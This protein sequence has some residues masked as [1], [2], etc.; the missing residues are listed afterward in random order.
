MRK[1]RSH[2]HQAAQT[3]HCVVAPLDRRLRSVRNRTKDVV[4]RNR[5]HTSAGHAFAAA[6]IAQHCASQSAA[7]SPRHAG[8]Q[9]SS[10]AERQTLNALLRWCASPDILVF[11]CV[12][13]IDRFAID[14]AGSKV[15]CANFSTF[16]AG[17]VHRT[18]APLMAQPHIASNVPVCLA[19]IVRLPQHICVELCAPLAVTLM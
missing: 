4:N 1:L 13:Q 2:S 6:S 15:A 17:C 8:P 11:G 9:C 10:I 14:R 7:L 5:K 18:Q 12:L 3:G 16:H 19:R